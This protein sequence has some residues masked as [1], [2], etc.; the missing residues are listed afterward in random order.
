[1]ACHLAIKGFLLEFPVLADSWLP[2]YKAVRFLLLIGKVR[3]ALVKLAR[4]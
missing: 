2:L 1:M 3:Q 4:L